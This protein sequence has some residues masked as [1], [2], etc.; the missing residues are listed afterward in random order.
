MLVGLAVA[1]SLAMAASAGAATLEVNA[2]SDDGTGTCELREA[3]V[4]INNDGADEAGCVNTGGDYSGFD[5]INFHSSI[6]G[7]A[8]IDLSGGQL[9]IEKAMSINGPG[10]D[11]LILSA[12]PSSRLFGIGAFVGS[13]ANPVTLSGLNLE[14][15]VDASPNPKG[16]A[17]FNQGFLRLTDVII[18]GNTITGTSG[19]AQDV[20]AHG[21]AIYSDASLT[22][23]DSVI[24]GNTATATNSL[25]DDFDSVVQGGA[26]YASGFPLTITNSTIAGNT[27]ASTDQFGPTFNQAFAKVSGGAIYTH[28]TTGLVLR[29]STISGN[30]V[31]AA[32]QNNGKAEIVGGGIF[33]GGGTGSLE[34]VTLSGNSSTA[35]GIGSATG[36]GL[37]T[38]SAAVTIRSSTI[39]ANSVNAGLLVGANLYA[40]APG[41]AQLRNTIVAEGGGSNCAGFAITSA[42]YN[43]DDGTSCGLDPG[44]VTTDKEGVDPD[45]GPLLN[46]GGPTKTMAPS[47]GP[48]IDAGDSTGQAIAGEDQRGLT[49]PRDTAS[50]PNPGDGSDI[51]AWEA[52]PPVTPTVTATD[53][54]S[55]SN[56]QPNPKIQG[57]VSDEG[58]LEGATSVSIYTDSSCAIQVNG[59]S[60]STY[61][62]AGING[63]IIPNVTRTFYAQTVNQYGFPSACSSSLGSN[64]SVSYT[65]D[66]IAPVPTIDSA[67]TD[68]T[69]HTVSFAFSATDANA[70]L[71]LQCSL[72]TGTAAFSA[73]TSPFSQTLVDGSY[74]FRLKA[75]DPAGNESVPV[76]QAF[77]I[78][79]PPPAE[80]GQ[81]AAALKKCKKKPKKKRKKCR[82]KAQRLPV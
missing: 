7:G 43:L 11:Q 26:I 6:T 48:A 15:G 74:T 13:V 36:G 44:T 3:V 73:C 71:T 22:L 65:H 1:G 46:H 23:D 63:G 42:G 67:P 21:A 66:N 37:A 8:T 82:K 45:L 52:Q 60:P 41:S 51:G 77:T 79:T 78:T 33:V 80:T 70:P 47:Q 59:N 32:S 24:T 64:A 5:T 75:T 35:N 29:Q 17:V 69:N 58:T 30:T 38:T 39:A 4:A 68:P 57:V 53:P 49:R 2:L 18:A 56:T 40:D 61:E 34:L 50:F 9:Q 31:T 72:D 19:V 76:T 12:G 81:R 62:G 10:S 25:N 28:S 16:G 20:T 27:V 14:D 55:P 54:V